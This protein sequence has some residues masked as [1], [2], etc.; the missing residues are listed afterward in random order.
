MKHFRGIATRYHKLA[1]TYG[2]L[3][4]L[5]CWFVGT[6]ATRRGP[7]PHGRTPFLKT[8]GAP[9]E[10]MPFHDVTENDRTAAS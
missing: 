4:S 1:E 10:M 3:L 9:T 8:A 6:R 5:V 7:S 2:G